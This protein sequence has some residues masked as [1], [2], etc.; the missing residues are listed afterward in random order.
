[1]DINKTILIPWR[2]GNKIGL[3]LMRPRNLPKAIT[4]PANVIAPMKIP[5]KASML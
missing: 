3:P 2:P 5:I 1:M 4:E